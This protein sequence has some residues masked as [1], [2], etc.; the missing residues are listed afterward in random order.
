MAGDVNQDG[1]VN[2]EDIDRLCLAIRATD[3]DL[4]FDLNQDRVVSKLDYDFLIHDILDTTP[5]DTNL[6]GIFNSSDLVAAAA[7]GEF[8]D[9][10][11][12]NSKWATGDWNCDLEFSTSDLVAALRAG[13][14]SATATDS[15]SA[16]QIDSDLSANT[17]AAI[18]AS[19]SWLNESVPE[20]KSKR[21]VVSPNNSDVPSGVAM[22][23]ERKFV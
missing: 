12:R 7:G 16:F 15:E 6:D 22:A 2:A 4:A 5:G 20:E 14:Y 18:L 11:V 1:D 21:N 9:G 8:E 17:R 13:A 23:Q 3:G 19:Q 10:V